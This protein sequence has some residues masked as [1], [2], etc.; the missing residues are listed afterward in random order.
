MIK[1]EKPQYKKCFQVTSISVVST[2]GENAIQ[3]QM[4]MYVYRKQMNA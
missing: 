2:V 1:Y 3:P 4:D